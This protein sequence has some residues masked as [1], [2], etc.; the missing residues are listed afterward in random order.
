MKILTTSLLVMLALPS[1]ADILTMKD[2]SKLNATIL[3]KTLEEYELEVYVTKSIKERRTVKRSDVASVE[4]VNEAN[5]I[6]EDKIA[7]LAPAPPFLSLANYDERIKI[8]KEFL[9]EHKVTSAGTKAS[10][11]LKELEAERELIAAGGIKVSSKKD[12]LITAGDRAQ[13]ALSIDSQAEGHKLKELVQSRSYTAALRQADF[14]ELNYFGSQA[15]RDAVPLM[16]RFTLTYGRALARELNELD[17]REER[18]L[19]SFSNLPPSDLQRALRAEEQR[20]ASFERVW[21]KEEGAEERWF[22]VDQKNSSSVETAVSTLEGEAERLAKVQADLGEIEE[23]GQLFRDGWVAAGE[24]RQTDLEHILDSMDDAG[25]PESYIN[26]LIDR[27]DPTINNPPEEMMKKE[28]M[29]E[30]EAAMEK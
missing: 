22:T 21:A 16:T 7:N 23:T 27:F 20:K 5:T 29:M 3:S 9:K 18:R 8:L 10:A 11:M 28:E 26:R 12:G 4:T 6:F 17:E 19:D 13:D 2:G 30:K 24:K 14:L 15:H 25:V 1:M